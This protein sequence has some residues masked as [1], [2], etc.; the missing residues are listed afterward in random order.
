MIKIKII[1]NKAGEKVDRKGYLRNLKILQNI[2]LE[3][4]T[5]LELGIFK[6][7]FTDGIT[8]SDHY[9]M[10][11]NEIFIF[12]GP[13]KV[14]V[15]GQEYKVYEGDMVLVEAGEVHSMKSL[16]PNK[17]TFFTIRFPCNP[18]DKISVNQNVI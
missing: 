9:H 10:H 2:N 8:I 12:Q 6:V 11:D 3:N 15:N 18:D 14:K 4:V 7:T 13:F 17:K 16:D 5:N 1:R